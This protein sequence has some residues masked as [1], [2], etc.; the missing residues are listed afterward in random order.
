[1]SQWVISVV[2]G[3]SADVRFTPNSDSNSDMPGGRYVPLTT[4][5]QRSEIA[6]FRS[7]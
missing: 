5:V 2:S 1:M 7:P 6:L 3:A 4:K